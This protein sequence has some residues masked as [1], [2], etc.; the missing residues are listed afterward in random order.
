MNISKSKK[1]IKILL[2]YNEANNT[3]GSIKITGDFFLYPEERLETLEK[4]LVGCKLEKNVIRKKIKDGLIDSEPF[5]F[6]IDSMTEAII[7]CLRE[8]K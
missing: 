1:L 2:T 7:G 6:D 3:I 5:G 4:S 8:R